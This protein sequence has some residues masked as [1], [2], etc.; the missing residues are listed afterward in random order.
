MVSTETRLKLFIEGIVGEMGLNLGGNST[1]KNF[2][3][4]GEV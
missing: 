3:K 1:F 2:R 4:E